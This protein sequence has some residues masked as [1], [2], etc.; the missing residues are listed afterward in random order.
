MRQKYIILIIVLSI[1][2]ILLFQNLYHEKKDKEIRQLADKIEKQK[3][4]L[5]KHFIDYFPKELSDSSPIKA[6]TTKVTY[7]YH[8]NSGKARYSEYLIFKDSLVWDYYEVRN[9]CHL[10]DI[11]KYDRSNF[12]KLIKELSEKKF[13]GTCDLREMSVGGAGFKYYFEKDSNCYLQYSD[14]YQL[15]GEYQEVDKL[16][17]HFIE[18]H[19]TQCEI[20]FEKFSNE[21]HEHAHFGEF[22]SLPQELHKYVVK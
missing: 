10:K 17:K 19:K 4:E 7:K 15:S 5:E 20:L 13:S 11:C 2:G 21:P 1:G 14:L 8:T 6:S 18:T 9:H 3:I 12:D 22:R 16:I